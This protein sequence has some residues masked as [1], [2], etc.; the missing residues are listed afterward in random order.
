MESQVLRLFQ[1]AQDI[2]YTTLEMEGT[3]S[4]LNKVYVGGI[5]AEAS[6]K[7]VRELFGRFGALTDIERQLSHHI[8][9]RY[10]AENYMPMG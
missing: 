8:T 4:M 5:P 2:K 10:A 6:E 7:D 9:G 1:A 3:K